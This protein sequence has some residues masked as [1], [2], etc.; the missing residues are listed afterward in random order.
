ML[1]PLGQT[2]TSTV[3]LTA[4][5]RTRT[6]LRPR[7]T[8]SPCQAEAGVVLCSGV[9]LQLVKTEERFATSGLSSTSAPAVDDPSRHAF[10]LASTLVAAAQS[11]QQ[12]HLT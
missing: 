6:D 10:P 9:R 4:H 11:A 7:G 1:Q 5:A 2:M 3:Q 8:V 12:C